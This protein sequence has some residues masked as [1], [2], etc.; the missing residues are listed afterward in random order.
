VSGTGYNPGELIQL[1]IERH[2]RAPEPPPQLSTDQ[3]LKAV[4]SLFAILGGYGLTFVAILL[5]LLGVW[6]GCDQYFL[7]RSWS[8]AD[9]EIANSELYSEVLHTSRQTRR[10]PIFG[11]RCTVRFQVNGRF[12]ESQADIGYQKSARNEMD[13]WYL[14]FPVG[15]HTAI[16]YDPANPNRVR[17]VEDVWTA[18][19]GPLVS[20][21]Y[22][23]WLLLF[24][25]PLMIVSRRL[26]KQH[27]RDLDSR[28]STGLDLS[29]RLI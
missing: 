23:G 2:T 21:Q 18:Y 11:F 28:S 12:Y 4:L 25:L 10:S 16:A 20:L 8:R 9:A 15:G 14:R 19:A 22:A 29:P 24:G 17:L 1:G 7:L 26:R 3:Q 27:E 6:V 5:G 13:D